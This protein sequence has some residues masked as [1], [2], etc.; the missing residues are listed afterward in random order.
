MLSLLDNWD[1]D[2][3]LIEELAEALTHSR[4]PELDACAMSVEALSVRPPVPAPRQIYCAE[5]NCGARVAPAGTSIRQAGCAE[6]SGPGSPAMA[7]RAR[8]GTPYFCLKAGSSVS[9]PY[10]PI[11]LP[12]DATEPDWELE[13]AVVVGRTARHVS[14]EQ[15]LEH[16]AGYTIAN[17]ITRRELLGRRV[18][19]GQEM[20]LNWVLAKSSPTFLPL[21]PYLVPAACIGDPGNL[22]SRVTLNGEV[23]Q[24]G[25]TSGMLFGVA[26]LIEHLSTVVPLQPGDLI[27]TGSPAGAGARPDRCLRPGDVLEGT[28]FG[29]GTQRNR[30]VE[31]RR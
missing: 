26:R 24:E 31:Q 9:G 21:G 18:N 25:S 20:G 13:L 27:L 2:R 3:P 23:V 11:L 19:D 6:H 7:G 12:A 10:D 5:A 22:R 8:Q 14:R 30:C 28:I 16:V 15:A 29:L 17:D 1:H 4:T